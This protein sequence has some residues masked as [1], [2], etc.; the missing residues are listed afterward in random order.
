D[1]FL[2]PGKPENY[3]AAG[4]WRAE[5]SSVDH[6]QS[7]ELGGGFWPSAKFLMMR[8]WKKLKNA[9]ESEKKDENSNQ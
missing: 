7:G 2:A 3:L 6:E 4:F 9:T 1:N 5:I 8:R